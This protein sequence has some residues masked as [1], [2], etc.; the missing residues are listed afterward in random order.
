VVPENIHTH[1][2]NSHW[3]F[4]EGGRS[5]KP[6]FLKESMKLNWNFCRGG[7]VQ[8]KKPSDCGSSASFSKSG[9]F[10]Q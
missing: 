10:Y 3:K 1:P 2:M 7:V 8:S 9:Q 4:Q 6:K 5:Q